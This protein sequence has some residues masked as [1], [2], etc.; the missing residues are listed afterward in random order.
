MRH[1]P[2]NFAQMVDKGDLDIPDNTL[3]ESVVTNGLQI[4]FGIAA[5]V[6]VLIIAI[7]ALRL[8]ISRGNAQDVQR[9]RDSIIYA[10]VGLAI[11]LSGF[12]IVTFVIERVSA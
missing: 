7:S 12:A 2:R 6:A 9:A 3:D 1:I 10:A 4:F 5:A 8:T 11:T